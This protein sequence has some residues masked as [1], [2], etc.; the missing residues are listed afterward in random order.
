[1]TTQD[2]PGTSLTENPECKPVSTSAS[3][4]TR[5]PSSPVLTPSLDLLQICRAGTLLPHLC[6]RQTRA[7]WLAGHAT[8][9]DDLRSSCPVD[10]KRDYG[11]SEHTHLSNQEAEATMQEGSLIHLS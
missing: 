10:H 7:H 5:R 2:S 6:L 9:R 3:G 1:M 4:S 11:L 8:P